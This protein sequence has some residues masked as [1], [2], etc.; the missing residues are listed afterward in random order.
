MVDREYMGPDY[1]WTKQLKV[2]QKFKVYENSFCFELLPEGK[3]E[4]TCLTRGSR[5]HAPWDKENVHELYITKI[6][7]AVFPLY[8][9]EY[10]MTTVWLHSRATGNQYKCGIAWNNACAKINGN[11]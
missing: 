4:K 1:N 5:M 2:G 8:G 11:I 3:E 10:E 6:G 9:K 7:T